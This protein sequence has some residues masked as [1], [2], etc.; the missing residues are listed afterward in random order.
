MLNAFD[1]GVHAVQPGAVVV[2]GGT[3]PNGGPRGSDRTRPLAFQRAL[4][5]LKGR[6]KLKPV[7]CG[8]KARFDAL[9]H[10]PINTSGGPS[11]SALHP[12]DASTPDVDEVVRTLR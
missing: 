11:R 9:A 6:T 8:T 1:A 3:A 12:D 5:C 4:L 10:H 2:T 7:T